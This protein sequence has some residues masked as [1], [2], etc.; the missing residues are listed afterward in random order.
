MRKA[1]WDCFITLRPVSRDKATVGNDWWDVVGCAEMLNH[2]RL[3]EWPDMRVSRGSYYAITTPRHLQG[4][5]PVT[6][7]RKH[8]KASKR[9]GR[10]ASLQSSHTRFDSTVCSKEGMLRERKR[11]S[12]HL[13]TSP[14]TQQRTSFA[15]ATWTVSFY[16]PFADDLNFMHKDYLGAF[17]A[18]MFFSRHAFLEVSCKYLLQVPLASTST[19]SIKRR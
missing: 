7:D 13:L 16:V 14:S 19:S 10:T 4:V 1:S 11:P 2:L 3:L 15:P 8:S 5:E 9:K 6:C 12:L 18:L 17:H